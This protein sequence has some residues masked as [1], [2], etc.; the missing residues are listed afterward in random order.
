MENENREVVLR[1][2]DLCT[3]TAVALM[4]LP[5]GKGEAERIA[6]IRGLLDASNNLKRALEIQTRY[7]TMDH[8]GTPGEN[9]LSSASQDFFAALVDYADELRGLSEQYRPSGQPV[10]TKSALRIAI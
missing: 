2:Q 10:D 4:R 3:F 5:A 7:A 6:R 8:R 9:D 1:E